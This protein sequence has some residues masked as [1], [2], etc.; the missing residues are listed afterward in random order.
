MSRKDCSPDN[1]ACEGFFGRL[2]TELFYPRN[3]QDVSVDQFLE[4]VDSYI[5]WYNEKRI[6]VSLGSLS[7]LEYRASL[8]IA[9]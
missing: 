5:H 9:A 6:K 2:K 1:A 8:G 7:P 3:W 4:T